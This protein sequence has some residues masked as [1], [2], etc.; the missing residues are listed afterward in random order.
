MARLEVVRLLRLGGDSSF[1]GNNTTLAQVVNKANAAIT[2]A[3]YSGTY[4]AQPHGLTGSASGVLGEDLSSL[5]SLGASYTKAGTYTVGWSFAGNADYNSAS[6]TSTVTI[7]KATPLFSAVGTTVITDGTPSV[8]L[9]GTISSASLIPTGNVTVTVD[10]ISQIAAIGAGGNFSATFA[11]GSLS[12]GAHAVAFNYGGDL[13]FTA[14]CAN[15][16]LDDTYGVLAL[17]DQAHGKH[18]GS[19]LPIQIALG[20]AS[21]H[22]VSSAG[23]SVTALGIAATTDTTDLVGVTDPSKV[24]TLTPAQAA[25][26]SNPNDVFRYQGGANPFYMFN[27]E[28]PGGLS[29]GT[30]RLYFAIQGD[31][32]DHW[33]TCTVG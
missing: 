15:G 23:V 22:D 16:S 4:D 33:V 13:N 17:F 6:G 1:L 8:K 10:G 24:G 21:G 31:P 27:L 12:V 3:P 14:A 5:L 20:S 29:A 30:Y 32:L 19:T 28:I 18:A 26:G 25:G 2:I 9:S 11:T 7:A